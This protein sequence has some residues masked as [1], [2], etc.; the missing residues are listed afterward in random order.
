MIAK[1]V[2]LTGTGSGTVDATLLA[3]P[4]DAPYDVTV[5]LLNV[6]GAGDLALAGDSFSLTESVGN[7]SA[8][9]YAVPQIPSSA[10]SVDRKLRLQEG[11]SLYG[12]TYGGS[13][14]LSIIGNPG[15]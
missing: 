6:S 7:G 12:A 8:D 1:T 5:S 11:D 10:T 15:C 9:A 14:T 2:V 13:A 3:G 4:V